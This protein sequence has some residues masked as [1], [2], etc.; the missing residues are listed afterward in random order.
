MKGIFLIATATI[1]LS[2]PSFSRSEPFRRTLDDKSNNNE[3]HLEEIN[4]LALCPDNDTIFSLIGSSTEDSHF[5]EVNNLLI[6][7]KQKPCEMRQI[8]SGRKTI[9]GV[10]NTTPLH[11][12]VQG[13]NIG[14]AAIIFQKASFV[15]PNGNVSYE[16]SR[17]LANAYDANGLKPIDYTTNPEMIDLLDNFTTP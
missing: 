2:A 11:L 13:D 1:L 15:N 8:L 14:I 12:A 5:Y 3:C 10:Q 17:S 6:P 7:Y 4:D 9:N 16:F